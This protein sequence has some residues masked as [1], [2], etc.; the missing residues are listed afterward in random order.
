M[1]NASKALVI[2]GAVLIAV[3]LI[4]LG[5]LIFNSSR[6]ITTDVVK[7]TESLAVQSFNERFTQYL[8]PAVK[9]TAVKSLIA[10]VKD[11]KNHVITL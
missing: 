3:L 4:S 9:P 2:A 5:V 6:D 11:E 10:Q 8:G 1:D 7:N